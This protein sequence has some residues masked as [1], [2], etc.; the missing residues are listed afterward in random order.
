MNPFKKMLRKNGTPQQYGLAWYKSDQW[1]RLREVSSDAEDMEARYEDW[2]QLAEEKLAELRKLGIQVRKVEVDVNELLT[3][4]GIH[5]LPVNSETR[6]QFVTNK[7][8]QS[9]SG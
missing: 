9:E 6:A 8:Q 3:W 1:R 4:C 2:R 5:G 7:L